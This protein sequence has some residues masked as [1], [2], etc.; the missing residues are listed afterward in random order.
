MSTPQFDSHGFLRDHIDKTLAFYEPHAL[1]PQGG[2]F[3][4]FLDDG[5]VYERAHRHLVSATRF[6][7]NWSM[8][9]HHTGRAPYLEW[10]QH[11]LAHLQSFRLPSGLYGWTL[12]AGRLQDTTAMAY[13]QA[14]VL[15][16][17]S[18]AFRVG[19]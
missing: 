11:A 12:E 13:G 15:L 16:A 5:T 8:A 7:F 4:Y 19:A 17:H 10:T 9:Y 18:H 6:V 14:F 3:H 1:D 2:F